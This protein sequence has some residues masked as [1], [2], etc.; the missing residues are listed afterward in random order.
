[1]SSVWAR[2][3]IVA[4]IAIIALLALL[5]GRVASES[6]GELAAANAYRNDGRPSRAIEH[7][8]RSIRWALPLSPYHTEAISELESLAKELEAEGDR[9][10]ALLAW[11]SLSG[12]IAATR[13][14]H[15]GSHPAREN[16]N[17][18]IARLLAMDRSAAVDARLSPE[19]LAADHRRLLNDEVSPD[20]F[21]GLVLLLGM[22]VWVGALVLLAR[23]GFDS[24]G[25]F[26]WATAQGPVWGALLGLV[27]FAVGLL[28][29]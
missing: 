17:D 16:A 12:G 4:G 28:F 21:W 14:L 29:A 2:S 19:Q 3:G 9:D 5:L 15:T 7:Y 20:P 11:R 24:A 8:R 22:A 6:R 26:H 13:T 1:M 10:L 27:S 25:R 18:Q 23:R